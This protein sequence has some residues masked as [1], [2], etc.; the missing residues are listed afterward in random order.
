MKMRDGPSREAL[1]STPAALSFSLCRLI[2]LSV[3][4]V[5]KAVSL[6]VASNIKC[7]EG[8]NVRWAVMGEVDGR[9]NGW[10]PGS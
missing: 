4:Q 6:V 8:V 3:I 2:L 7:R 9:K 10:R 1:I 5:C